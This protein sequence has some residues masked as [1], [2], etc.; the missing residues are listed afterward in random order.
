MIFDDDVVQAFER[1]WTKLIVH[2]EGDAWTL[3]DEAVASLRQRAYPDLLRDRPQAS[4]SCAGL[5]RS[6]SNF[7]RN[8]L[9]MARAVAERLPRMG[10][11]LI[12]R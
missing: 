8:A 7:V 2:R 1:I 9:R 10:G 5:P 4:G 3:M 6:S 12:P 11:I